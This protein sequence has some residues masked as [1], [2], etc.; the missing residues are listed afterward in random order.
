MAAMRI[1]RVVQVGW[2]ITLVH[3]NG[4]SRN[5]GSSG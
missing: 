1:W 4:P 5:F 2:R 3:P